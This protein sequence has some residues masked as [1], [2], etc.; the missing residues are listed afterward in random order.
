LLNTSFTVIFLL[1]SPYTP[2]LHLAKTFFFFDRHS[3]LSFHSETSL[4]PLLC[5]RPH[6]PLRF[7]LFYLCHFTLLFP[8]LVISFS[9][10]WV[11]PRTDL[12]RGRAS[13]LRHSRFKA[14]QRFLDRHRSSIPLCPLSTEP[15]FAFV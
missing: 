2:L 7:M 10:L 15:L 3:L 6:D 12:R 13:S 5:I 1:R 11:L 9:F 4:R 14:G 8:S